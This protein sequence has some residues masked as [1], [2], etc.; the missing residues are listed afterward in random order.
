MEQ[1]KTIYAEEMQRVLNTLFVKNNF[2][3]KQ[4]EC[5]A[6]VHTENTLNGVFSHGINR[7][8]QFIQCVKEGFVNPQAQ[9]KKIEQ[10]GSIERWD[11]CS[12]SG[13]LNAISCTHRAIELARDNGMGLVALRNT[14][15][16]M[17]AGYY[18]WLAAQHGCIGILFTNTKANM[19]AWGG[20][21]NRLGNNPLVV[22][23]PK[24]SGHI[25]LDMALSQF[26]FGKIH[27]YALND[28]PLPFHGGWD[29]NYEI[30]TKPE[31]I[32]ATESGIPIGY[33]KGSALS[34][35]LDMLATLLA[36]GNSTYQV[37]KIE[38]ETNVSQVFLCI[39]TNTFHDKHLQ[40]NLLQEI[41]DYTASAT[42]TDQ[43]QQ[44]YY[45]GQRAMATKQRNLSQG[46]AVNNAIWEEVLSL[47]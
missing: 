10:F 7:V 1:V 46:M 42:P 38:Q 31:S 14:N 6:E 19:P 44:I 33:W 41:I 8:P 4:A 30:T 39:D 37:E 23:I 27:E 18:G 3:S 26:S 20:K 15:H 13:V 25:V 36:A 47:L 2:N 16:W 21:E 28:A 22:S 35:V 29:E 11:G 40:Q 17:R 45:P 24:E 9:A 5:L 34:M 12:A 43:N 32:L